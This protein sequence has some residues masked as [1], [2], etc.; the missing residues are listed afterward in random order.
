MTQGNLRGNW[1]IETQL[2]RELAHLGGR[3]DTGDDSS[4]VS[5][6][7]VNVA[8]LMTKQSALRLR[9]RYPS[10]RRSGPFRV[11]PTPLFAGELR[12]RTGMVEKTLVLQVQNADSARNKTNQN[13]GSNLC[14][15]SVSFSPSRPSARFRPVL[16]TISS[17]GLRALPQ[18]RSSR[19]PRVSTLS[20]ALPLVA[21]RAR[22]ATKLP[23]FVA[24]R[25]IAPF[26]V[27]D[28]IN[29]RSGASPCGGFAFRHEFPGAKHV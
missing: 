5:C 28:F 13:K 3:A 25:L 6:N 27:P 11:R 4:N 22:F 16:T 8:G 19:M 1:P 26:G 14:N 12:R 9:K 15:L 29:R 17:A 18:V 20:P 2:W 21:L 23:T 24:N 7:C 10:P